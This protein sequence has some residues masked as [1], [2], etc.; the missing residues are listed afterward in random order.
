MTNPSEKTGSGLLPAGYVGMEQVG[1]LLKVNHPPTHPPTHPDR[2]ID[3]QPSHPPS[4][5]LPNLPA[6]YLLTH[7][8]THPPSLS[9]TGPLLWQG[10]GS[11]P[12]Q[13]HRVSNPPTHPPLEITPRS[14]PTLFSS[15]IHPPTHLLIESTSKATPSCVPSH[16][17]K[18][19]LLLMLWCMGCGVQSLA[20]PKLL[21]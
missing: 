6:T 19:P 2:Q 5:G 20:R 10:R 16:A 3:S 18:P 14:I 8:P 7:P 9:P 4:R 1:K 21:L 15:S 13:R 12:D 17:T 11:S